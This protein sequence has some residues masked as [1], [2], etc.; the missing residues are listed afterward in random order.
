MPRCSRPRSSIPARAS[1]ATSIS[2]S[3]PDG[4][5]HIALTSRTMATRYG[6]SGCWN[7][8]FNKRGRSRNRWRRPPRDEKRIGRSSNMNTTLKA[9]F[10]LAACSVA[11]AFGLCE[12]AARAV[13]PAPPDTTRGPEIAYQYDPE[14]RYV[15]VPNQTGWIDGGAVTVNSLGFRGHEVDSPKP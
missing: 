4:F 1:A 10:A 2:I 15:P 6:L 7:D 13:L 11:V 14:L 3:W 5:A 9:R 8:G 12:L